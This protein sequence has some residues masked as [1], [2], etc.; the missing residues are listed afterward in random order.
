M[1]RSVTNDQAR[2]I[3]ALLETRVDRL[4]LDAM[5]GRHVP[6]PARE[7]LAA[8]TPFTRSEIPV[9]ITSRCLWGQMLVITYYFTGSEIELRRLGAVFENTLNGPKARI[10]LAMLLGSG[11]KG[12]DL[13]GWFTG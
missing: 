8:F 3:C 11:L 5:G 2:D 10:E 7:A 12:E 13:L 6:F 1:I 4:V 9:V